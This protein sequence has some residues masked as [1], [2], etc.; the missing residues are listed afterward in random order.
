MEV[1]LEW[2]LPDNIREYWS[3][4]RVI[5]LL[6]VVSAMLLAFSGVVLA[7]QTDRGEQHQ[8]AAGGQTEPEE[9]AAGEVLVKFEPGTPGRAQSEAHRQVGGQV[10]ETI[11]A[12][13]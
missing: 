6:T 9:F 4:R 7:Q 12:S 13:T 5:L 10:K 11:P 1:V 8:P 2:G 3:M